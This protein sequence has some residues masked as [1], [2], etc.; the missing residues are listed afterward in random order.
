M[1]KGELGISFNGGKDCTALVFLIAICL[2]GRRLVSSSSD[3]DDRVDETS[4]ARSD[5]SLKIPTVYVK[6]SDSFEEVDAFV[7]RT[8]Q[9][10]LPFIHIYRLEGDMKHA[11]TQF[12]FNGKGK[13]NVDGIKAIF[14]GVRKSDPYA[15]EYNTHTQHLP[16]I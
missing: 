10:Y 14:V 9:F 1:Q 7:D 6:H 16:V 3:E 4:E 12:Q 11:L 15:G 2:Y 5:A 13:E 8:E